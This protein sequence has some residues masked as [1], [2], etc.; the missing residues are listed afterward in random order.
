VFFGVLQLFI[1]DEGLIFKVEVGEV[2][3]E[4]F[5]LSES[6]SKGEFPTQLQVRWV[7]SQRIPDSFEF[8]SR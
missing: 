6:V 1:N 8:F 5:S 2:H 3:C 7:G 4:G